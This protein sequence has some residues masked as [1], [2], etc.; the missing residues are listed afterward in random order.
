MFN[1]DRHPRATTDEG[2]VKS[3]DDWVLER[4]AVGNR[5]SI[6]SNASILCGVTIGDGALVGAGA[7][8]TRDVAP[9]E[10]VTGVPARPMPG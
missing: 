4:T 7:V 1:N 3:D 9:G 10:I 5:A 8:V 6:G 2:A